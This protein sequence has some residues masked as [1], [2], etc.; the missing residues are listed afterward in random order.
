MASWEMWNGLKGIYKFIK[1]KREK[2]IVKQR[3]Q[4]NF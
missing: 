3:I 2:N 4:I 1:K